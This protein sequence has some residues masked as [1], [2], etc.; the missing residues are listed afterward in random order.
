MYSAVSFFLKFGLLVFV[1]ISS[2]LVIEVFSTSACAGGKECFYT[3]P[4]SKE[5]ISYDIVKG[6]LTADGKCPPASQTKIKSCFI[7]NYKQSTQSLKAVTCNKHGQSCSADAECCQSYVRSRAAYN[8]PVIMFPHCIGGKCVA[9]LKNGF[10]CGKGSTIP[11]CGRLLKGDISC[12]DENKIS[13]S[14]FY[15]NPYSSCAPSPCNK[16]LSKFGFYNSPCYT[17]SVNKYPQYFGTNMCDCSAADMSLGSVCDENKQ[18]KT[19]RLEGFGDESVCLVDTDCCKNHE[20]K[21][22][23]EGNGIKKECF[24]K[25]CSLEGQ[26][27]DCGR[28]VSDNGTVTTKKCCD[29]LKCEMIKSNDGTIAYQICT[30]SDC[31]EED[32]RCTLND[33]CCGGL[34]CKNTTIGNKKVQLC[35]PE[36]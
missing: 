10:P 22:L 6:G 7:N 13:R 3:D 8:L 2:L 28:K 29:S 35:K 19:C 26:R 34:T 18:C 30:K 14:P 4:A 33:E 1:G 32:E 31:N 23:P 20:C 16:D 21:E 9:C 5:N 12:Q 36:A 25:D 24:Q 17:Y 15:P 11:C 27:G